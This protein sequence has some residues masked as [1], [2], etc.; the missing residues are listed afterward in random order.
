MKK[1]L[2]ALACV[3]VAS[4]ALAHV[5]ANPDTGTAGKYF[6]T[7]FRV[8]HGCEGSDT[9]AL[10]IKLPAGTVI[11][12][13]QHKAGWTV[14]T[15]KSKLDKPVSIGHGKT[16]D[17]QFDEV[18]WRG[19]PLSDGEYDDFGLLLKLPEVPQ[20]LWFPITQECVKGAND[21]TGIPK[22]GQEWHDLPMPAPFVKVTPAAAGAGHHH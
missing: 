1:Y 20:T 5:T 8:S 17:E 16:A 4:P 10:T 15:K 2:L 11:L 14:S 13:P 21:W 7:S 19:G 9:V 6:A 22:D 3:C 12:K 18:T